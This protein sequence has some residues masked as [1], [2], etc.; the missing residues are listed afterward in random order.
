MKRT[1]NYQ[2]DR[3]ECHRLLD[4]IR[5][6]LCDYGAHYNA[7]EKDIDI[8]RSKSGAVGKIEIGEDGEA[9]ELA[10]GDGELTKILDAYYEVGA[11]AAAAETH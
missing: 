4:H 11:Y 10:T 2:L 1:V 3:E 8:V 6:I 9:F 5:N 7:L